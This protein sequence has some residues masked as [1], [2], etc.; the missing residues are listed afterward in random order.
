MEKNRDYSSLLCLK[1]VRIM[2]LTTILI[3]LSIIHVS[4]ATSYAQ[5]Q[6]VSV[7]V[8]NGS[9]YD[10]VSQI[11]KQSDFM[12]FY[13]SGE[14]DNNQRVNV[15]A[16]NKLI[17]EILGEILKKQN[18]SYE[19][20]G[21][22]IV[23]SK[24][25]P[26]VQQSVKASG[27]VVD[28]KGEPV[29]GA[30]IMEV[31]TT[32]GTITDIDGRFTLEVASSAA[33]LMISYIGYT[34]QKIKVGK[35]TDLK[36][37]L[38]EDTKK[39]DEVVVIGYGTQKKSDVS[40]SVA[41]VT[42]EKLAKLPTANAE[43][44]LEGAAPGLSVDY[45]NGGAP[46][47]A[48]DLQVR[49]V[50]SLSSNAPL[51]IIDGVPGDM[52]YLNPEDIKTMSIL[53]D[54]AT[55][56]IYGAR[57]AAGVILIETHRGAKQEPKITFSGYV[58]IDDLPKRLDLCNSAEFIQ[59]RK[60][61]YTNA[62]IPRSR[63][64][65]YIEA[66]EQDP[67]QFAD[68]DWQ[69]EYFH[70]GL[71][72][73]YTMGYTAGNDI[74]NV[75]LSG[76]YSSTDGI[77]R[78]TDETKY[79]FRLNS[80]IVRGKFKMG[81]SISYGRWEATP[82]VS[83]GWPG[84]SQI[85]NLEP[86]IFCRDE[87]NE[88]GFGGSISSM[89]MSDAA[90]QVAFNSLIRQKSYQDYIS[91]SGYVQYE[92][93]KDLIVKFRASRNLY[94]DGAR[95]FVPT[96]KVGDY[97][98]NTRAQ[99]DE[100]RA[101]TTSD[102]LEATVNYNLTLA[103]KHSV[104]ALFGLSQEEKKYENISASAAKFENNN[105]DLLVHGQEN[106][107]VGGTKTRSGLRSMFARLNY[108]YDLRYM[109][110][111]SMRYDGSTRF[112][113]NN[114]W[115]FFPSVSG[116]WN[117]AN[118]SFW[119][120][121]KDLISSFKLRMSYGGLGNQNISNYMYIPKMSYD[122]SGLNY[123]W[124]GKDINLGYAITTLPSAFIKWETTIYKNIGIDM[125]LWNNKL[126][127]SLEGY[128]KN[129]KDMLSSK[130]ISSSTGFGSLTV[131]DGK[132]RTTGLEFQAIYHGKVGD[133]KYDLDMN[134]THY[135]SVLKHMADP[136]YLSEWGPARTYVG[137][138]I[139]EMWVY[140]TA[141][142]FRNQQEV[143]AWNKEHGKLDEESG[144][145]I[146]LQAA[147]A[148][149]DLRFIDTNGDGILDSNDKVKM[150]S[151]TP[152]ATIG[153]NISMEYKNFDL[154]ANFFGSF[155]VKRYNMHRSDQFHSASKKFNGPRELLNAWTP[156]NPNSNIPRL[157]LG[158]PNENFVKSSDYFLENGN[159]LRLNNL[160][161]GYN[162]PRSICK[163]LKINNLRVYVAATRLFTITSYSGYDPCS[164]SMGVDSSIYP[165]S[166]SYMLGLKFGF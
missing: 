45:S 87:N 78:G 91:A 90:N 162:L 119:E 166:R 135:K 51:V 104:S 52:S 41:T 57:A 21:K 117:I 61:A 165:L 130:E 9:F 147:A 157:V 139:G 34:P 137:G 10:L 53:K 30:N 77:V 73:K 118:E 109:I 111:A 152:K 70:R 83:T 4:A 8:K 106:F 28:E 31:G 38:E 72:H 40:G 159:F 150:G 54:A 82:E 154:V 50:T 161:L 79:G 26:V 123:P 24:A 110:M 71:T 145:W 120:E 96:Y 103:E 114:K 27:V 14:I 36:V 56:A 160:Q 86:L 141:G 148:P 94:F 19:I 66:Y 99:L 15:Q 43:N 129:T 102:L 84:L 122:T 60:M 68:T 80:D 108:N 121:H 124:N 37:T 105:M 131:N 59:M 101:K 127:L 151:G 81:E 13:K 140:K 33:E 132:L 149:G 63:W 18:L 46:G 98:V 48:P 23:I 136:G 126:E 6:R 164:G 49:G 44:A 2:K 158:D 55:A 100:S 125:G 22:H 16:N 7:S 97:N 5:E 39:L 155:G 134:V 163:D 75:A 144:E 3:L 58:G 93:I 156:E 112:A 138:E 17:S 89:G 29:I 74:M 107:S 62:G 25:N 133:L 47:Q 153:F 128:I 88:G 67:T 92:P 12:F 20:T 113:E 85:S 32:N 11:E 65:K 146:P 42:G 64:S 69:K 35:G 142:I 95:T 143:D 115:G 76:F 116:A 1:I